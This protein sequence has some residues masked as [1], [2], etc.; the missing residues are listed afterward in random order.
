MV[1]AAV[2]TTHSTTAPTNGDVSSRGAG[3]ARITLHENV[4]VFPPA[5]RRVE[6]RLSARG[7]R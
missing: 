4:I 6:A 7:Q 2:Q 1:T 5:P 3:A